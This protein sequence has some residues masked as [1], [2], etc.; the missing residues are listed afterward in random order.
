MDFRF[1]QME[2]HRG[3]ELKSNTER[4]KIFA[5]LKWSDTEEGRNRASQRKTCLFVKQLQRQRYF[6]KL[7]K[8]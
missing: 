8:Y 5:S 6:I 2:K 3:V 1:A 4:R 7:R